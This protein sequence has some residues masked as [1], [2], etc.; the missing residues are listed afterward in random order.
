MPEL[1]VEFFSEEIPARMQARAA[2][3]LARLFG[4]ALKEADLAHQSVRTLVTP[5]RLALVVDGIP[6]AQPDRRI[7]RKGPRVGAPQQAID[8]FLG[9]NGLTLDQ[10]EVREDKKGDH[11]VAVV[12]QRGQPAATVLAGIV[13]DAA[14]N[15][16]WPKSMRWGTTGFRWVRPLHSILA[17]FDGKAL[18]GGLDIGG[19]TIAFGD[20]TRGH[21]FMA[22]DEI[23]VANAADYVARLRAAYVRVD[24]ADRRESIAADLAMAAAQ[25]DL[26]A[27]DDAALLDEVTGLVEWPVV[28]VGTIDPAF[29]EL[30]PEVLTTSMRNH[31][32]YF[33]LH[34]KQGGFAANFAF[35]ANMLADDGG[36]AIVAGNERVLR[37]RLSDARYFWDLDRETSLESRVPA[38]D[39]IVFHA[40]LGSL[41]ER[42][43]RLQTLAAELAD[44]IPDCDR[45]KARSA[46]LLAKADLVSGMVGE[47]P[48]LQGLMGRYYALGEGESAEVAEAIAAHYSPQ[49][50]NDACPGAPVSVAVALADKLDT[51]AG[52]WAIDEKPTGSKDPY[53]LRRAALGVIRLIL[54]NGLRLQLRP[55]FRSAASLYKGVGEADI[56]NLLGFF[57]DRL[58]VHL[59]EDNVPHHHIEAVFALAEEDDLAR[60]VA[61]VRALGAFLG[62]EDGANLLTA[63]RRAAN[64]V[65]AEERKDSTSFAGA[66][67]DPALAAQEESGAEGELWQVLS[68]I[69]GGLDMVLGAERFAGAMALLARMRGPV[70]RFFDGVT[71]NTDDAALRRNRLCLL[72][73]IQQVMNN[74]ADFSQIEG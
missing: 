6:A 56:E 47:F 60:I 8:G 16:G 35:V 25:H 55:V 63:Y 31:Q 43:A 53:A 28:L 44:A 51:L 22:P 7:E 14:R 71:V 27:P 10:C 45:D 37:A 41:G 19:A 17:V 65:R 11:Y 29:M 18:E 59:R 38:L 58:K 69:E 2:E 34:D 9:A 50:P 57:V 70:D 64:I 67:Y 13:A 39:G 49:G 40:K 33:A 15:L 54:E 21:R 66:D 62:S 1:L 26:V 48:E 20:T 23:R 24:P 5:R 42:V 61:R 72:A 68:E 4:A 3:D 74:V 12:E 36:A 73:R 46:A 32:K 30:P 52:F